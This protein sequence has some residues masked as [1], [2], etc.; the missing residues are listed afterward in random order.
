MRRLQTWIARMVA[1][2]IRAVAVLSRST[3][4]LAPSSAWDGTAGS[5]FSVAPSDPTRTTAK[6]AMRLIVPPNQYFTDTLLVGVVAMASDEGTMLTKFG[7]TKVIAHYEGNSQ[8][9]I[10]PTIQTFDDANGNSVSYLGWWITL[11]RIGEGH[12]HLYFEAVP[13]DSTMQN[14]IIG[15][16]QFSPQATLHDCEIEV[17]ATPVQVTGERYKTI[18][19]A[20]G[21]LKG[22]A[23]DNPRITITEAGTYP[24][25]ISGGEYSGE[26]YCT[27]EA[28]VSV[29][30]G[31]SGGFTNNTDALAAARTRY[32]GLH[33]KGSNIT[34][35]MAGIDAIYVETTGRGHW[36]DGVTVG[37]T[38]G[39]DL[40][41]RGAYRFVNFARSNVSPGWI[42]E[43]TVSGV[44]GVGNGHQLVRGCTISSGFNDCVT[45]AACVI[46]SVFDDWDSYGEWATDV[47]AFTVQYSGA[48][49]T[50]TLSLSGVNDANG[51]VFTAKVDGSSVG[52]Y[53]V[54]NTSAK[55]IADEDY[56]PS[57]V[58]AW[59]NGL[60]DWSATT[61]DDTRRATAC[62]T[63][64]N[65]GAA[66][67]D[68]DA[69]TS[70]LTVVTMFD[71]HADFWQQSTAGDTENVI[72]ANNLITDFAGQC[73]FINV[74]GDS[75]DVFFVNNAY[76][77]KASNGEYNTKEFFFS[78]VDNSGDKTHV[79]VAHNSMTQGWVFDPSAYASDEY[80]VFSNNAVKTMNVDAGTFDAGYI[81]A[82]NHIFSTGSD[83]VT[84]SSGTSQAGDE[85]SLWDDAAAGDFDPAGALLSNLAVPVLAFDLE[86]AARGATSAK[87]ALV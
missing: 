72:I 35:D 50:A 87:G 21:Y 49:A 22:V 10:R 83:Q 15:P 4:D 58:V 47:D 79:V 61:V 33:F 68:V 1:P 59:L 56:W 62:S 55:W 38:G 42:T 60:T 82:N 8:D 27:I 54:Y 30:I 24:L 34:F 76:H 14:R 6:P 45:G 29:T 63:T 32:D 80:C 19:A 86:D 57:D 16:Y 20:L 75:R 36:F 31:K 26:G 43:C 85:G 66:F 67:T 74:A 39:R 37:C 73:F 52:T 69:K 7:L 84:V 64:G 12:A 23:A 3:S 71:L 41:W 11:R 81:V 77:G 25:G 13:A 40:Y 46:D 51:R 78:Q 65:K 9:I 18:A 5:G 48:G 28:S 17:A 44:Q 2:L 53:T 70:A